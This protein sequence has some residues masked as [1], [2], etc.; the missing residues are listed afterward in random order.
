MV[1]YY[2]RESGKKRAI[3]DRFLELL[4]RQFQNEK[5]YKFKHGIKR[6]DGLSKCQEIT[7]AKIVVQNL[8]DVCAKK[9]I[10]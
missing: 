5:L 9:T 7:I 1:L 2:E 10:Y 6:R 4:E 8:A 3:K